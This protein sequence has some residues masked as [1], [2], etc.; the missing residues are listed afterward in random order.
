MERDW[1]CSNCN[2]L[3]GKWHDGGLD[4]RYKELKVL[5]DGKVCIECRK[6]LTINKTESGEDP[7]TVA[8]K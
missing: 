5:V 7:A 1:R 3:L 8:G 4:I 2:T 6:C